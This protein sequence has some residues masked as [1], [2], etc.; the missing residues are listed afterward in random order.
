M[1]ITDGTETC[2]ADDGSRHVFV[3]SVPSMKG[4]ASMFCG[5]VYWFGTQRGSWVTSTLTLTYW[6][7]GVGKSFTGMCAAALAMNAF[8]MNAGQVPPNTVIRVLGGCIEI[9][10]C[11]N[12]THTAAESCGIAPTNQAFV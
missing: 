11:G 4:S 1:P 5:S 10:P 2:W 3:G 8:Q 7:S 6:T 9:C 12:P